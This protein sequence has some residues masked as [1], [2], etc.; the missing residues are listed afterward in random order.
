LLVERRLEVIHK[1]MAINCGALVNTNAAVPRMLTR[2][3][4]GAGRAR[5]LETLDDRHVGEP[6]TLA[7]G[8][9]P[10]TFALVPQCV[11]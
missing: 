8:L 4:N 3:S 2:R 1:I 9:Q 6:A 5:V 7:H 11:D 10:P